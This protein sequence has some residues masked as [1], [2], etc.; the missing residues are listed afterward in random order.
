MCVCVCLCVCV[1]TV[2]PQSMRSA[3]PL[4]PPLPSPQ[5]LSSHFLDSY[6][7]FL[8]GLRWESQ[9]SLVPYFFLPFSSGQKATSSSHKQSRSLTLISARYRV[10]FSPFLSVH[11]LFIDLL[12]ALDVEPGPAN[13]L[14]ARLIPITGH[15]DRWAHSY[16]SFKGKAQNN[17][18]K[19]E[20]ERRRKKN[21]CS[22]TKTENQ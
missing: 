17:T 18:L 15:I 3:L 20:E 16:S 14:Q 21:V 10:D 11:C 13:V 12:K 6:R 8:L 2:P 22:K 1:A 19:K 4:Q 5:M 9:S 7:L